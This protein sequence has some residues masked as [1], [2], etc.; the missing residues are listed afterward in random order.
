MAYHPFHLYPPEPYDPAHLGT[1]VTL[2]WIFLISSL[3]FSFWLYLNGSDDTFSMEWGEGWDSN[4]YM[5]HTGYWSLVATLDRGV[6]V[7]HTCIP[8][9]HR[10]DLDK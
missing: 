8:S 9:S 4:H 10:M 7:L 3:N 2:D 5:V 1:C 6:S